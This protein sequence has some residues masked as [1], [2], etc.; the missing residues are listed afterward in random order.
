[1]KR[2][3][4]EYFEALCSCKLDVLTTEPFG[5]PCDNTTRPSIIVS[6]SRECDGARL[7]TECDDMVNAVT[8]ILCFAGCR[9]EYNSYPQV[10]NAKVIAKGAK[11]DIS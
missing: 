4:N 10:L 6:S 2:S 9:L 7:V 8:A 11:I 5:S 1:M 3:F